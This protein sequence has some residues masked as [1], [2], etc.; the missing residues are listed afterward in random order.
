MF[1]FHS[2]FVHFIIA[3]VTEF[4]FFD[5]QRFALIS[6]FVNGNNG[7]AFRQTGYSNFALITNFFPFVV[8]STN[9]YALYPYNYST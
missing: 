3:K 6:M 5:Y 9:L 1:H 4:L 2:S 8:K 7:N